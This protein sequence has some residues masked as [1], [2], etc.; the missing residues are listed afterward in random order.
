VLKA[1]AAKEAEQDEHQNNDQD[2]P[3]DAHCLCLL[4]INGSNRITTIG[5]M[6]MRPGRLTRIA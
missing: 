1:P 3:Q 6:E 4:R 2:N 5:R